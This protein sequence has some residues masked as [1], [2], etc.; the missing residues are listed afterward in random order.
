M[1]ATPPPVIINMPDTGSPWW[2]VPLLAGLFAVLG[3]LITFISTRAS[4]NRRAK[5]EEK[6]RIMSD[7]RETA[8]DV[9]EAAHSIER[10]TMM[11]QT[12]GRELHSDQ[13]TASTSDATMKLDSAWSRFQVYGDGEAIEAG[14]K[15]MVAS[16]MLKN[17]GHSER[18]FIDRAA[19]FVKARNDFTEILRANAGLPKLHRPVIELISQEDAMRV[20]R[21]PLEEQSDLTKNW[22]SWLFLFKTKT[23]K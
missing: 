23:R 14:T 7:S 1:L 13:L 6:E 9:I 5:R 21:D 12:E 15:L 19:G 2:S 16:M 20:D 18:A 4:D 17:S 10:L 11:Q 8:M 3:S 22:A